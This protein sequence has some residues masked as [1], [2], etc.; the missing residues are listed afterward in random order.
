MN[1]ALLEDV[2]KNVFVDWPPQR[3]KEYHFSQNPPKIDGQFGMPIIIDKLLGNYKLYI[4]S[5]INYL[6]F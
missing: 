5:E 3:K 6:T 1:E 2:V 4:T